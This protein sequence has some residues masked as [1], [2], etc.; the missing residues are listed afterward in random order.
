MIEFACY[1]LKTNLP[2][3]ENIKKSLVLVVSLM[4]GVK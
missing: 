2:A 3:G 4:I 1:F